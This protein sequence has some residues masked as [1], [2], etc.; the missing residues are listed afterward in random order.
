MVTAQGDQLLAP[1]WRQIAEYGLPIP[2][3]EHGTQRFAAQ[4][5]DSEGI[6]VHPLMA[7]RRMLQSWVGTLEYQA[8]QLAAAI[9][10]Q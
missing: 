5:L 7:S 1:G 3:F 2:C 10:V 6:A 8:R 4:A 9:G